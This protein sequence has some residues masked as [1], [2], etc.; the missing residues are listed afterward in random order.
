MAYLQSARFTISGRIATRRR[1]GHA[2]QIAI[3]ID[4]RVPD[5]KD[6]RRWQITG[7]DHFVVNVQDP[8]L[9]DY[10]ETLSVDDHIVV[11]GEMTTTQFT[12]AG[13]T[14]PLNST[15]LEVETITTLPR[16]H[17]DRLD[18]KPPTLATAATDAVPF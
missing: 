10:L 7:T 16:A 9:R 14:K 3:R 1:L 2:T 8:D 12:P 13:A 4:R 15:R 11:S 17:A 18:A 5:P 6:H